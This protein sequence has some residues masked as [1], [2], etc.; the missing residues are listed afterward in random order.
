MCDTEVGVCWSPVL[1][2]L[3]D[4][5]TEYED[6]GVLGYLGARCPAPHT[7]P[8]YPVLYLLRHPSNPHLSTPI[9]VPPSQYPHPIQSALATKHARSPGTGSAGRGARELGGARVWGV[10]S[11]AAAE[12]L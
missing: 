1:C 11:P 10:P 7:K 2:V 5:G 9:S 4:V 6:G 8:S 12:P 3:W